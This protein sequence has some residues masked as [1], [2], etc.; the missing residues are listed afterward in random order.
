MNISKPP[1]KKKTN[2]LIILLAIIV[3]GPMMLFG[4][5]CVLP[6]LKTSSGSRHQNTYQ[7]T[8]ESS[9]SAKN[10]TS[11]TTSKKSLWERGK[12]ALGSTDSDDQIQTKYRIT[13]DESLS[14]IKRSVSVILEEKVDR[15]TLIKI[16]KNI[17]TNST[18]HY[19]RTF[20]M[21]HI[22]G[23]NI[24]DIAWATSH[25]NPELKIV[26]NGTTIEED[27]SIKPDID[28]PKKSKLIGKWIDNRPYNE[29]PIV[30]YKNKRTYFIEK[31]YR[32]GSRSKTKL[33]R[34][35]ISTGTKFTPIGD[36]GNGDYWIINKQKNLEIWDSE[37]L[38]ATILINKK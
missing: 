27:L 12:S 25:F 34:A 5:C 28:I 35:K 17:K 33:N 4:F 2:P 6:A 8:T 36:E 11:T 29:G 10:Y 21:Y 20:I 1:A 3:M 30:I 14:N 19:E 37:G 26:I 31:I 15:E 9:N 38:I 23:M 16:A 7:S 32:D 22:K 13:K 24:D 18:Q